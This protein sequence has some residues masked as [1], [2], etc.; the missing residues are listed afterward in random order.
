MGILRKWLA[1]LWAIGTLAAL[2]AVAAPAR[3]ASVP[4][5]ADPIV[6][7][8]LDWTGQYV[9]TEVAAEILRR[10]GYKVQILQTTQVPMVDALASGQV[11]ASLENWY[12]Q[13]AKLYNDTAASGKIEKIG[14]TGLVGSEGWYYPAYVEAKCPGLPDWRALKTCADI[15]STADTAPKGRLLD[16]PA[17]WHPD[18]QKWVDALGLDL[19]AVPSGGEGSTAAELKSAKARQEPILLQWWEPTWVATEYELKQIRLDAD[20]EACAKAKATGI[21]TH[22]SFDCAAQG[23]EIGKLVWPGMKDK[24]PAAYR[25]L[26]AYTMKNEWQGPMAMAIETEGKKPEEVAKQ[27]VDRNEAIWKP[28]VDAAMGK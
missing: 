16:Y 2:G 27:W 25:F 7:S 24:W 8:K 6:L 9:T 14:S 12:Q 17:E 18:A 20:G 23:I 4:E 15:F 28:W 13:L 21:D 3:A 5:S 26:K 22:K 1:G 19:V 11:T 10:M